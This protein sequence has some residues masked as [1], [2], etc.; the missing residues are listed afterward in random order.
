LESRVREVID[1]MRTRDI[2]GAE[3][4]L[5]RTEGS[6]MIGSDAREYTRDIDEML[7]MMRESSPDQSGY[8]VVVKEVHAYDEGHV[9]WFDGTVS[10]EKDSE[11]VESRITGVAH[12]END[13]W[14]FVQMHLS[15]GVPN[16][17]MFDPM[18]RTDAALT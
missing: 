11:A 12:R 13:Q 14:C 8:T 10:F 18:F 6:V 4:M 15:V 17:D 16:E 2:A 3:R 1:A 5:S 9:G 7:Q